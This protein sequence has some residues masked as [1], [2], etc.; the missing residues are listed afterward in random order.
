MDAIFQNIWEMSLFAVPV[1]LILA[2]CSSLLGKRYGTKWR[3]FLWMV[4]AVRLCIPIQIDLPTQMQGMQMKVPSV[5]KETRELLAKRTEHFVID[6]TSM[7]PLPTV[8][9]ENRTQPPAIHLD[10]NSSYQSPV[11][12]FLAYP[13]ILTIRLTVSY[14]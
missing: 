12:F 3:Y 4:I 5:Q 14:R 9:T 10:E 13:E 11:V 2:L 8:L 7:E 1:I 6:E